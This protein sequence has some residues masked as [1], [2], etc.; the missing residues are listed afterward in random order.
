MAC[1]WLRMVSWWFWG[2]VI[3]LA[4]C[5]GAARVWAIT[6]FTGPPPTGTKGVVSTPI[7]GTG[8]ASLGATGVLQAADG[9]G[10]L[11]AY[12][13]H[14]CQV[15]SGV[16][17]YAFGFG[18]TGTLSCSDPL[19]TITAR[20]VLGQPSAQFPQGINL[21]AQPAGLLRTLVSAGAA[22]VFTVPAPAGDVVGTTDAQEL[23]NKRLNY[24]A[25]SL[26]INQNP[27]QIN[28]G[29]G[30]EGADLFVITDL[31]QDTTIGPPIGTLRPGQI[32]FFQVKTSVPRAVTWDG[33]WGAEAGYPLPTSTSA[34]TYD[35]WLFQ[36]NATSGKL[37][38]FYNS[39][40]IRALLAPVVTPGAYTCPVSVTVSAQGQVTAI[41]AG[42]CG[43]GGGGGA[44][45]AGGNGDVQ[46][47]FASALAADAD[48]FTYDPASHT[49]GVFNLQG[50]EGTS[51]FEI[52]DTAGHTLTI[53]A[54]PVMGNNRFQA[55][56]DQDG[57]Y[58]ITTG[59]GLVTATAGACNT[60]AAPSG[61]VVG[62]TDT[63]KLE[64]KRIK[65]RVSILTSSST[66]TCDADGSDQCFMAQTGGAGTLT[67]AAPSPSSPDDG[68]L[69]MYRLKCTNAQTYS[70]HS[71]YIASP[72][73]PLPTTC[74]ADTTKETILGFLYSSNLTKWQLI[75][76][77]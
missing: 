31:Q 21:G 70:F 47:N 20:V 10:G 42:P 25:V 49:L 32:I 26:P 37:A 23:S 62:T 53:T 67:V 46:F 17:Q 1:V 3:G 38:I 15:V 33:A 75:A 68:D 48:N 59:S 65:K 43:G 60:V 51:K 39:Q 69:L 57:T 66:F 54:P 6:I 73:I 24:R 14:A 28:L 29:F 74:P 52:N 63:Q 55:Y 35:F 7:S 30:A 16:Q 50:S 9:L 8:G 11:A 19:S 41:E 58:C 18:P 44:T 12:A 36:Y 27:L 22:T 40:T 13:G 34:G 5:I 64:N 71:I 45:P 76:S 2:L 61:A 4:L 77:N 72:S 56:P